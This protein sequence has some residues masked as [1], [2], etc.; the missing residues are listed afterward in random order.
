MTRRRAI[1]LASIYL[2]IGLH[3]AHWKLYGRTLAPL[4]LNEVMYTLEL[5]VVTAGFLFMVVLLL[6]TLVVGRFFCGWA[7]HIL[8]LEDLAAAGLGRVGIRLRPFR[9][10]TLAWVPLLAA[11][12]M[13]AWPQ[14]ARLLTEHGDWAARRIGP[15]PD[16]TWRVLGDSEGWASFLTSDFARNLPGPFIAGATFL[17]CGGLIVYLLGSRSFCR[18]VCPYGAVFALA[19]R[20]APGRIV[21]TGDC[22]RCGICTAQCQSQVRVHEEVARFGSVVDPACLKDLDCV[23]ICPENALSFGFTRPALWKKDADPARPGRALPTLRGSEEVLV[24]LTFAGVFLAVRGLY[25]VVPFLLAL[26]S[27]A[28][29]AAFAI[30]LLRAL[31]GQS[32]WVPGFPLRRSRRFTRAGRIGV[33]VAA[34]LLAVIAHSGWIRYHEVRSAQIYASLTRPATGPPADVDLG[35]DTRL[36]RL[37]RHLEM[38]ARWGLVRPEDLEHKLASFYLHAGPIEQAEPWLRRLLRR[39]PEDLEV[40]ARLVSLLEHTGRREEAQVERRTMDAI[41]TKADGAGALRGVGVGP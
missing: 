31:R 8:A 3:V 20:V 10:R 29:A 41:V 38:R 17:I 40:R 26:G 4:E 21:L 18:Y 24:A 12:Y 33:V 19:D 16:F 25:S 1:V 9:S 11:L 30:L 35:A 28:C 23:A 39:R 13:F 7:C 6:G 36:A 14:V 15:R 27:A 37:R 22:S 2:A 5:G 32:A 34:L